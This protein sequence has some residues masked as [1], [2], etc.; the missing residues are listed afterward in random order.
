MA[1]HPGNADYLFVLIDASSELGGVYR[2]LEQADRAL[3][4]WQRALGAAEELVRSHPANGYYRHQLADV[5]Y[6]LA[7]L[8]YHER[9]QPDLARP[10]SRRR[11]KSRRS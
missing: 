1:A 9:R 8:L 3:G 11:S 5:A 10:C 4:T 2:E 6:S 7:S